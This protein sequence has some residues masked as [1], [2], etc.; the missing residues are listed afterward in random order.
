MLPNRQRCSLLLLLSGLIFGFLSGC[1]TQIDFREALLERLNNRGPVPLSPD[2]PYLAANM[3]VAREAERSAELKGFIK[4][5]GAPPLIEVESPIFGNTIINF[6]YPREKEQYIL[7]GVQGSW[8]I[9]GPFPIDSLK[10]STLLP[11]TPLG[12]RMKTLPTA[13]VAPASANPT[14]TPHEEFVPAVR[15]SEQAGPDVPPLVSSPSPPLVPEIGVSSAWK[16]PFTSP[17]PNPVSTPSLKEPVPAKHL[18]EPRAPHGPV[19]EQ[20]VPMARSVESLH[21]SSEDS[22]GRKGRSVEA[23]KPLATP[24]A[25]PRGP[26]GVAASPSDEPLIAPEESEGLSLTEARAGKAPS[27]TLDTVG[28]KRVISIL[29]NISKLPAEVSPRGDV[30]HYVTY[31]NESLELISEWYTF[32]RENTPRLARINRLSQPVR[33]SVGDTVV[34]PGYLVR[35]KF[36]LTEEALLALRGN[37]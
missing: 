1:G 17:L 14:T 36:R 12:E 20:K 8:L 24:D 37:Q 3:M 22:A 23:A 15:Q 26:T 9:R 18:P 4:F 16:G 33:L 35:N 34:V 5:R 27:A 11:I 10:L 28:A 30:V 31:P 13:A 21:Q 2:N 7:E 32:D 6:Y 29:G 19:R 25:A